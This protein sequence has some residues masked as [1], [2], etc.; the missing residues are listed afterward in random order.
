[1]RK[2][3]PEGIRITRAGLF[4]VLF[5]ILIGAAATNTGNNALYLALAVML[6]TLALSGVVSR[7]NL[8]GLA[9]S[10]RPPAESYARR[11]FA[12][13]FS[14]R[15]RS[16]LLPRWL[17]LCWLGHPERA[18]LTLYLVAGGQSRGAMPMVV[19]RRGRHRIPWVHLASIFPFGLFRKGMR[20]RVDLELLA[21]P[22][23]L[24]DP[25][26]RVAGAG[27][28]GEES[29]R[30]AGRGHELLGLRDFR[31]GD[32]PRRIHWKQTARLGRP[33]FTEREEETGRRISIVADNGV[34]RLSGAADEERFER[35]VSRAAAAVC[36]Y[37]E[38]GFEVEL[39]TRDGLVPFGAGP[40]QRFRLLEALA[41]IEPRPPGRALVGR[42]PL[43]P[44]LRLGVPAESV[45]QDR[46]T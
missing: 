6:G 7:H 43:V 15:N 14:L 21:F 36:D 13:D 18:S 16:R 38:R 28:Q 2:S 24:P 42:D 39:V 9:I 3:V 40:R 33:V 8:T 5:T 1:M 27:R 34:G 37:L 31:P 12:V 30:R 26:D 22:E 46:H 4:Y 45:G 20:L 10:L 29:S 41:L 23:L 25:L 11:P 17:L 44:Q 32:D 35:M 19:P